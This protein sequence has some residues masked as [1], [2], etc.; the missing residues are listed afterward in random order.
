MGHK[1]GDSPGSVEAACIADKQ[2]GKGLISNK[3]KRT[4]KNHQRNN[5]VHRDAET[6]KNHGGI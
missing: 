1:F 5:T 6:G 3:E 4:K 2:M